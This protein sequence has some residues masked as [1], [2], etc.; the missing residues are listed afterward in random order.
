MALDWPVW[1]DS[2]W[3]KVFQSYGMYQCLPEGEC[4]PFLHTGIDIAAPEGTPVYAVESGY[5]KAVLTTYFGLYRYWRVVVADSAGTEECDGLMYAHVVEHTIPV[6]VG[7]WVEKG[8]YLGDI[9]NW[10]YY[11]YEHLHFSKIRYAGD[12]AAWADWIKWE[13][14]GNPLEEMDVSDDT[15]T[16]VFENAYGNQLLAFCIDETSG[17]FSEGE[18]L[19]G[20]VDIVCR[21][22]DYHNFYLTKIVPYIIE[23]KIEGDSS[24]PW[25]NSVCFTGPIG[26]YGYLPNPDIIYKDDNVCN[27]RSVYYDPTDEQD[28]FFIVT[29]TDG[30]SVI[31][32]SDVSSSWQTPNFRNGEYKI[33]VRASDLAANTAVDSM[34]VAVANFFNLGGTV[35]LGDGNPTLA[36]SIIT[37]YPGGEQ[38]T[39]DTSGEYSFDIGGGGRQIQ[40]SRPG[41]ATVDTVFMM[42]QNHQ[43]DVTLQPGEFLCG[44]PDCDGSRNMLDILY[45]ISYLYKGGPP[46]SPIA[47]GDVNDDSRSDMLDILYLVNYLY[48]GGPE[49]V[50]P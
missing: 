7:D 39:T 19:S 50:C 28:Y 36:G 41:Y 42:N 4:S 31:E 24:V 23:Y 8:D 18:P 26:A 16:P 6:S 48:K 37:A 5:V 30:D 22:Y 12:S 45:L 43:L 34:T 38:D 14:V 47:A 13:F 40:I 33:F 1:P 49:P 20:N 9:V 11:G 10:S 2:S 44:D 21:V 35:T 46:P 27:T 25:T 15:D 29:N 17:Y 32:N 3:H